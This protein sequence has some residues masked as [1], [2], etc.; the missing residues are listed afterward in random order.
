MEVGSFH[1]AWIIL[2]RPNTQRVGLSLR[3]GSPE[4][5]TMRPCGR[6]L[7]LSPNVIHDRLEDVGQGYSMDG[8][9]ANVV[10]QT[11]SAACYTTMFLRGLN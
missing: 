6:W 3:C 1:E 8:P 5:H 11:I 10:R 2:S 9:G 7:R 4:I